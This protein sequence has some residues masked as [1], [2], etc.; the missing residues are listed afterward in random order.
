MSLFLSLLLLLLILVVEKFIENYLTG[1]R[2]NED[3][4][5]DYLNDYG[6]YHAG[7]FFSPKLPSNNERMLCRDFFMNIT[8]TCQYDS[9]DRSLSKTINTDQNQRNSIG[10]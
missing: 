5:I 3:W 1:K 7:S 2:T 9:I 4:R 10:F 6:N 8:H